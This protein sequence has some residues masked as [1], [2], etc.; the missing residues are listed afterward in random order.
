MSAEKA[1]G[2]RAD[3]SMGNLV[4]VAAVTALMIGLNALYVAAEFAT[5]SAR[6]TRLRQSAAGGDPLARMLLPIVDDPHRL[7]TYVAACQLGITASSLVLGYYGQAAIASAI[8]PLLVGLGG[9][10]AAQSLS[11]ALVLVLLTVLQ[12]VIGEL[13][14]KSVA[15]R[16]PERLAVLTVLPVRWSMALFRPFIALF[17]GAGALILRALGVPPATG[18]AHVHSP[19]ELE[20][21]VLE[22]AKGGLLESDERELLA[23]AFQIG[24]KTAG[25]V[26][27]PRTRLT[28]APL[29]TSVADLLAL[30]VRD[31]YS[32]IPLYRESID[33]IVGVV[34]IRDL[35][36]LHVAGEREVGAA[37]RQVPFVPEAKPAAEVWNELRAA[38]SYVAIVFD[39]HGGTAGMITTED[40]I[41]EIF[42]EVEDE[43]D[44]EPLALVGGEPGRV[45]VPG[46]MAVSELNAR[47]GLRLPEGDA[48]TVGGL[49]IDMLGRAPV[50]GDEVLVAATALRVELVAGHAVA[51]VSFARPEG[52]R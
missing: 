50:A 20:L 14:P 37:L 45:V 47:Y 21:L 24:D 18:H 13:V 33:Q 32:R 49:V 9:D 43:F 12:V 10:L 2:P 4:L 3:E 34:H 1:R 40:L 35:Y 41:E 5:V 27:V 39:E 46:D 36:R 16:Y 51:R 48:R 15:L 7:D 19:E 29:G 26:M 17:N 31:G 42:G 30:C 11:T 38:N 22:S 44:A 23:N 28:A 6:R 8:A 25:D 52:V